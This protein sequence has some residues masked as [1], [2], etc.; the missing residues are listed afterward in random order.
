MSNK[1]GLNEM[2][3]DKYVDTNNYI[4]SLVNKILIAI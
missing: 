1:L 2:R 3:W 4:L